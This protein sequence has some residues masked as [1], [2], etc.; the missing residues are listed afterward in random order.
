[1][2]SVTSPVAGEGSAR[3]VGGVGGRRLDRVTASKHEARARDR[4]PVLDAFSPAAAEWFATTF[5]EPTPPQTE[6]W[7]RIAAGDH[8]LILAPTGSGKTLTA[9]FWGLD[10][11]S[12]QPR[13]EA[14]THRTRIL[15]ISPLRA[16]AVDVEKNLRAPLQGVRL[17][18]Q[19]LGEPFHEPEVGLRTGDTPADVRRQLASHPPDLLITTP[20]SLYLML[21]SR[22]R[23]TL[24][25]VETVIIDEIHALAATKRGA[26]LALTLERL[27]R[28]TDNPPQRIGL[29]ATQRPLEEI[30]RFL[31]GYQ[32]GKPGQSADHR[33]DDPDAGSRPRPVTIVDAGVRKELDVEVIVPVEDMGPPRR[34]DRGAG[35][36][37]GLVGSGS[38]QHL[39]RPCT[40]GYSN[41]CRSTVPR[42]C[43]S[44][45]R[46]L[47]ERLAIRLNELH[48]D[49]ENRAAESMG[50]AGKSVD[51]AGSELVKA[52]HGSAQSGAA[53]HHRGRAQ[54]GRAEGPGGHVVAG[55]GDRHG[56]R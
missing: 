28:V 12:I 37:S 11:L 49:G 3:R 56:C 20:E 22:V 55:V 25:G 6:G 27:E 1:M 21:T 33:G 2:V 40:P 5:A 8:T 17:A 24:A 43:S 16:L 29:S 52:H 23:E 46:R 34:G 15:Y 9:F 50:P 26:H 19:R 35:L 14:K 13:P 31:G 44:N 36:R 32:S 53:P 47:A 39:A 48:H 42:S 7:P 18:A 10:R 45:S 38:A 4:H 54:A 30:A 51:E 41:S